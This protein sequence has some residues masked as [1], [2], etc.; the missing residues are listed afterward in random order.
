MSRLTR[1]LIL[2]VALAALVLP[3]SASAFTPNDPLAS[4]Q[5]YLAAD[6][7][8]DFWP[9]L[10]VLT[11]VKVAVVDSG[12]DLGH[13][14]FEGKIDAA[15]SFV[16]GDVNDHDGHGTFVAGVIA[17]AL[18]NGVGIAGIAFPAH[19][20]VA[21]VVGRDGTI[22]PD[23]EAHA[24][25]WAADEGARVINLSLGGV[26]DPRD[27]SRDTFSPAEEAA[28]EYAY[29]KGA[30]VVAAVGNGD[31]APSTPWRYAS[32]PAALPHVIGVG[33]LAQDG[34]V[35]PY[36]N[37]DARFVDLAAP[38]DDILSTL[39][40]SLTARVA[41]TCLDQGYSDCGPFDFRNAQGTSFA[42][43]Q[44]AAAAALLLSVE[45][46]L[47]PEQVGFLLEHSAGDVAPAG[48][49][50]FSGWGRLDVAAA[51]EALAAGDLPGL[52][53]LE[54]NDDAGDRAPE[55]F[56]RRR[57]ITATADYWDD[58]V[59]VYRVKLAAGQTIS[60]SVDGPAGVRTRLALWRPGTLHVIE[61]VSRPSLD[62]LKESRGAGPAEH[63]LYR[64]R[65]TGWYYLEVTLA[66]PGYGPYTLQIAKSRL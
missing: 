51:L 2:L 3:A 66:S 11:P 36:S 22:S 1:G 50:A 18:D 49:D 45:P 16:G 7:A 55:V 41:P 13:P 15:R 14:E 43:P 35:P 29:G 63:I 59:D 23:A 60:T 4:R 10:P 32:Y 25:R 21:K 61:P 42:A 54:P 28:V 37:R 8:F 40:R 34:T 27:L 19:L 6:R 9:D 20:V 30:V 53:A 26:R 64:A 46:A 56:G 48:R 62:R 24:I 17:A 57:A 38:G 5:W 44:V 58:P 31:Q 47:R 65:A 33:A 12:I 39:P 52:D